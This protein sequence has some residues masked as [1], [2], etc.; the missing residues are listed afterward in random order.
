MT[1]GGSEHIRFFLFRKGVILLRKGVKHMDVVV[2]GLI[3]TMVILFNLVN[4][5]VTLID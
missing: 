1:L 4:G 2:S 5:V 3:H